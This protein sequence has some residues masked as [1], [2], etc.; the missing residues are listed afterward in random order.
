MG[1]S[2]HMVTVNEVNSN[3]VC[4]KG[5]L[6]LMKKSRLLIVLAGLAVFASGYKIFPYFSIIYTPN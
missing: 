5:G 4:Y 1:Y 2:G 3:I 6:F